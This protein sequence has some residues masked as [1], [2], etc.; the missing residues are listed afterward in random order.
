MFEKI[1]FGHSGSE[2]D[3]DAMIETLEGMELGR[4]QQE[5]AASLI[6]VQFL[7]FA[8]VQALMA[9]CMQSLRGE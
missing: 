7:S 6:L 1:Q 9:T 3:D 5:K 8:V 2:L 4:T